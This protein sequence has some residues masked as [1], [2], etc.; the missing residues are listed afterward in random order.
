MNTIQIRTSEKRMETAPNLYGIFLE[1]I[2]RAVD[3][4]LYPELIRNRSFEDSILPGECSPV[5]DGYAFET[6]AGWRDEFNGG[7]GLS[8]WVRE[9]GIAKTPVPGW[10][11]ERAV[12]ELDSVDTL[13]TNRQVSL[14][15]CFAPGGV[16][17]NIGF[18]GIAQEAGE[19]Y[20][21]YLFAKAA[22][23]V[24]IK[25]SVKRADGA[26]EEYGTIIVAKSG[27]ENAAG[28]GGQAADGGSAGD[29]GYM[30]YSLDHVAKQSFGDGVLELSCEAGGELRIGFISLMPA[31]TYKGHGL[32]K[33]IV[34]LLAGLSPKFFRFPGG[35][36]VEG[37]T[38]STAM[39]FKH[40]VGPV[41]ER[42]GHQLM[43]HYRS[44]DAVGFHEYLQLC[45][46]LDMEPLYVCNCGM[47]CQ[48]RRSVLME[49]QLQ[50]EMLQDVL[51]AIEYAIGPVD[52]KWGALRASMGHPEPFRL[53][54]IEIGNENWGPAY[55][56]RYK[57]WYDTLQEK[58]PHITCIANT[59]LE[60]K[61]LPAPIVDE[62]YY[63]T[64][65]Y[66][67]ENTEF[68]DSYDR[69][70]PYIFL[71][72]VA[73]V[74]G[75]TAQLYG[76]LAEAAY[77]TG[78]E[79]NQDVVTMVSY[80]PLLENVKYQSWFPNLLRFDNRN[81]MGIPSYYVWKM[82]GN[83]RGD[84]VVG[85]KTQTG[86]IFRPVKGI[87]SLHGKYGMRCKTP[88]W[89]GEPIEVAQELMG[90]FGPAPFGGDYM[91]T[92][93][94]DEEQ[95]KEI[96]QYPRAKPDEVFLVFG[97]EKAQAGR[98][99]VT[100]YTE[101][102]REYAFGLFPYRLPVQTYVADETNP[103]KPWNI[104]NT[105]PFL[106]K[107]TENSS[108]VTD[109][110]GGGGGPFQKPMT[111][112]EGRI[113]EGSGW[114]TFAWETDLE[115]MKLFVDDRLIHELPVP[116][117]P[118]ISSVA[119]VTEEEI[120]LKLVNIAESVQHVSVELDC[121]V[122]SEY[123]LTV[124]TGEKCQMNTLE[125]PEAVRDYTQKRTGAAKAFVYEAPALSVSVLRL[126]KEKEERR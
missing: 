6:E 118:L 80:A 111:E 110:M 42:P 56:E 82:F 54:Y 126:C 93:P 121:D 44:Y 103:P 75:Y 8:K 4:G 13:H 18:A 117:S 12:M 122:K 89:N 58:Y 104:E 98:F 59:H 19:S 65:E 16:L 112:L 55:E 119:S 72:E 37:F 105:R 9:N 21:L 64:A 97:E 73:V 114:H 52:S 46:D 85:Q 49:G 77:F 35:C 79:K 99:E 101:A 76:A 71:G 96:S 62:H 11:T 25:V 39:W 61:G 74:R 57:R 88:L 100:V 3:G 31:V 51:D 107:T 15:V 83:N 125:E 120:I 14:K 108:S 113:W 38:L 109:T 29:T 67:T 5:Q 68:F 63:D 84:Y 23:P 78:V 34:E 2:N 7:E 95:K 90:H 50:D 106:W 10:Y 20:H 66:F 30:R 45:E 32:R 28:L 123:V 26:Q 102:E 48:A 69:Q 24:E 41:W 43:W 94:P 115:V 36:I 124:L 81:S 40:T 70:G 116:S 33:D 1:D 87:A 27:T 91:E 86:R 92:L 17:R 60:E 22:A 53:N 47:T